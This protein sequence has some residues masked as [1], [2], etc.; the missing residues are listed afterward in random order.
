MLY[1][2]TLWPGTTAAAPHSY[3]SLL[4]VSSHKSSGG[5]GRL[6]VGGGRTAAILENKRCRCISY[7]TI[8]MFFAVFRAPVVGGCREVGC[9]WGG[10]VRS[11][12]IC[13]VDFTF[14]GSCAR[15]NCTWVCNNHPS[16]ML[17]LCSFREAVLWG[18]APQGPWGSWLVTG[19]SPLTSPFSILP[20]PIPTHLARA[21]TQSYSL[22]ISRNFCLLC[23]ILAKHALQMQLIRL[24]V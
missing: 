18:P 17:L 16:S 15:V 3:K 11:V 4:E 13:Q 9:V 24:A 21:S 1:L 23:S 6:E 19:Q 8:W 20:Y 10:G 12:S 7:V 14:R 5:T 2:P 22:I